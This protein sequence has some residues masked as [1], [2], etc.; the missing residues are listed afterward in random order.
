MHP[1]YHIGDTEALFPKSLPESKPGQESLIEPDLSEDVQ[2][3]MLT[4]NKWIVE[5]TPSSCLWLS[6]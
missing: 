6:H 1:V 5:E 4:S 3:F 2:I